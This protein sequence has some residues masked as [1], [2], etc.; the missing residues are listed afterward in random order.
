M[1][2]AVI[3]NISPNLNT[4]ILRP[5]VYGSTESLAFLKIQSHTYVNTRLCIFRQT[6]I[7][8]IQRLS[9]VVTKHITILAFFIIFAFKKSNNCIYKSY[10][11]NSHKPTYSQLKKLNPAAWVQSTIWPIQI[12]YITMINTSHRYL[13]NMNNNSHGHDY[14][15]PIHVID[16]LQHNMT[17][18][19]ILV[20]LGHQC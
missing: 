18:K 13:S 10:G 6:P 1:S 2:Y 14:P 9:V 17:N 20:E 3:D 5:P 8:T 16:I 11:H 15:W 19:D 12:I 4:T 7:F